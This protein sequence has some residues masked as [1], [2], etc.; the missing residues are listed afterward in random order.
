MSTPKRVTQQKIEQVVSEAVADYRANIN[1]IQT[2]SNGKLSL[3]NY[4]SPV[5]KLDLLT[6]T[7]SDFVH[8][9]QEVTLAYGKLDTLSYGSAYE[10]T[11]KKLP[12][13]YTKSVIYFR[14]SDAQIEA[15]VRLVSEQAEANLR[16]SIDSHN[17]SLIKAEKDEL[18][19]IEEAEI[20]ELAELQEAE[21]RAIERNNRKLELESK[22]RA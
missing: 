13:G 15:D 17:A 18:Q 7:I 12:S 8:S 16:A 6:N 19:A 1:S 2:F 20:K 11:I 9:L 21:A 14:K 22:L 5:I 10:S 4:P 3:P